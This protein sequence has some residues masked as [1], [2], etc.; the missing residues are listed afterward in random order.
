ML[1][2]IDHIGI[3]VS[4]LDNIRNV[5]RQAFGLLP[6]FEEELNSQKIK[7]IGYR[8]G[9]TAIEFFQPTSSDSTVSN[10][11][12]KR[13]NTIHHI[14][15]RVQNLEDKLI[16][17]TKKGFVLIDEKAKLGADG[18]KIAFLH[19]KSFEG[20]LIELCEK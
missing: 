2:E 10:F 12:E 9:E 11:L 13:G 3:L 5:Y 7:L 14:A 19:P 6:D 4:D 1:N 15:F 17:L 18:R 20:I 8:M 16:E